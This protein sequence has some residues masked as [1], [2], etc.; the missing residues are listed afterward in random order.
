MEGLASSLAHPPL[1]PSSFQPREASS[2]AHKGPNRKNSFQRSS[3]SPLFSEVRREK[4][5]PT[6]IQK[7][8][9][10][11]NHT[12]IPILLP[13]QF[14]TSLVILCLSNLFVE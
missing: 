12:Q 10:A 11:Y 6:Q 4:R 7:T 9:F 8:G 3:D 1:K 14:S 5:K 2:S 13:P